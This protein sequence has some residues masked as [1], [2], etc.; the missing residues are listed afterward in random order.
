MVGCTELSRLKWERLEYLLD[1]HIPMVRGIISRGLWAERRYHYVDLYAGPGLYDESDNPVLAGEIG[2]PVRAL[3][4]L[5]RHGM[6]YRY[7]FFESDEAIATRLCKGLSLDDNR[8]GSIFARSCHQADEQVVASWSDR[9][10]RIAD[11]HGLI[12]ADPNANDD[13][14]WE[15]LRR[16]AYRPRFYRVDILV[17]VNA[18]APK[19]IRGA[20]PGREVVRPSA[21][22]AALKRNVY[23]WQPHEADRWQYTLAF[24]TNMNDFPELRRQGFHHVESDCGRLLAWKMDYSTKE[25][26][27]MDPP[28]V[29]QPRLFV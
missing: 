9:T 25:R 8:N 23:L 28:S 4:A 17:N 6:A 13:I 26:A 7:L 18:T 14:C 29:R 24:C 27:S 10:G 5:K 11:L 22:L 2:S 12:F 3:R 1:I 19:R 21:E 16:L 15:T 20:F